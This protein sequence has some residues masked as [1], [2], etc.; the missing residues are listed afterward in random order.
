MTSLRSF[1]LTPLCMVV[2]F[3]GAGRRCR[4]ADNASAPLLKYQLFTFFTTSKGSYDVKMIREAISERQR[5]YLLFCYAFT[6]CDTVSSIAGHGKA[7]LFDKFCA[8]K[9]I[10][11]HMDTMIRSGNAI[12]KYIYNAP[13]T[14][15]G[16]I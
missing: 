5:R 13:G 3:T 16:E 8:C 4:F 1:L 9:D 2:D 15:L 11:E 14:T 10:D 6:G 7:T 12:F